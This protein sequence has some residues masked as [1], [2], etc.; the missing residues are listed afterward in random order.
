M[1]TL[2]RSGP[3]MKDETASK[4]V[5]LSEI[6]FVILPIIVIALLYIS[7]SKFSSLFRSHEWTFASIIMFGQSIVKFSSGISNFESRK[8]WEL[9]S[10]ILALIIVI[11]LVPS[12]IILVV[13]LTQQTSHWCIYLIQ[14]ILFL[15][16]IFIYFNIG[17]VGQM[18][19]DN[20]VK[21]SN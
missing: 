8:R 14:Y 5:V 17:S 6:L 12:I 10:I 13:L 19:L 11:G 4:L 9:V 7:T 20:K 15:L 2:N 3:L 18:F 21:S 16:S 1:T